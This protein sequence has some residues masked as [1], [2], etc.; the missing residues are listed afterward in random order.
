MRSAASR[1]T[2]KRKIGGAVVKTEHRPD[3]E[4]AV[5][6]VHLERG[7]RGCGGCK[8]A[9]FPRERLARHACALPSGSLRDSSPTRCATR[10]AET[11]PHRRAGRE[12]NRPLRN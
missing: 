10:L 2:G 7:Q 9:S 5:D 3:S 1:G 4:I 12:R 6:R 8:R 11:D